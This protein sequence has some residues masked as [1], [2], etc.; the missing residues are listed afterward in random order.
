MQFCEMQHRSLR[1]VTI[2]AAI[3]PDTRARKRTVLP[4]RRERYAKITLSLALDER[5]YGIPPAM[6]EKLQPR[7][8]FFSILFSFYF[9][10]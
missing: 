5:R 6:G 3:Q 4:D 9:N 2:L 8:Y 10:C 7:V 1:D